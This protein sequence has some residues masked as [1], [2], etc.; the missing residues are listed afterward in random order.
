METGKTGEI[1]VMYSQSSVESI[2][3]YEIDKK[4]NLKNA[5]QRQG[6]RKMKIER[7]RREKTVPQEIHIPRDPSPPL[8]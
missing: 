1:S 6:I 8:L 5:N 2:R 3:L 4:K 7:M